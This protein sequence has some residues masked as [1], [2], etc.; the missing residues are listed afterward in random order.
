MFK[1]DDEWQSEKQTIP[2]LD[3]LRNTQEFKKNN[4]EGEKRSYAIN[5]RFGVLRWA[6]ERT[7]GRRHTSVFTAQKSK[8]I[9]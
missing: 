7:A 9:N 1:D 4:I 2:L 3:I 8:K 5:N 6:A